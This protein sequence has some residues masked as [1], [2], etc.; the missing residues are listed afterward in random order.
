MSSNTLP[1]NDSSVRASNAVHPAHQQRDH[2]RTELSQDS[3]TT[4]TGSF[5]S[6]FDDESKT[7]SLSSGGS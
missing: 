3:N 6:G 7:G 4:K 5:S 2:A 1:Y